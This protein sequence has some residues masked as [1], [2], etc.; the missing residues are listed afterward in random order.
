MPIVTGEGSSIEFVS[1]MG[2]TAIFSIISSLFLALVFVPVLMTYMEKIPF[3][4]NIEI[5]SEGYKNEFLLQ[6]YRKFLFWAYKA[7]RRAI[8]IALAFPLLGFISFAFIPKDFFPPE[9]RNMFQV[10]IELPKNASAEATLNKTLEVRQQIID[11]EL[12]D[13]DDEIWWIG[14]R[15]PRILM[16]CHWR[17]YKKCKQ[18]YG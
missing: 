2:I 6:K 14:S 11:S 15:L 16:E 8:S 17:R 3:F 9:D 4:K 1:G 12:I 5:S 13:I 18:Q 10:R 7:P